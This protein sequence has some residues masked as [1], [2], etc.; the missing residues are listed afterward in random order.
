MA[1]GS[2]PK[3]SSEDERDVR[4]A[5]VSIVALRGIERKSV[6]VEVVAAMLAARSLI[7]YVGIGGG[8]GIWAADGLRE[9]LLASIDER[10]AEMIQEVAARDPVSGYA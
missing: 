5:M 1:K 2:K 9:H 4:R 10:S 7:D 8:S 6:F 3:L